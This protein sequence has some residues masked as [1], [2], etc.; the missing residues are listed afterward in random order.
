M[1]AHRSYER[2]ERGHEA[3]ESEGG[4][5][6]GMAWAAAVAVAVMAAFLALVSFF[7]NKAMKEVITGETH[8]AETR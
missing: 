1:E 2:F 5:L 7:G 8:R 4:H 6:H 3:H